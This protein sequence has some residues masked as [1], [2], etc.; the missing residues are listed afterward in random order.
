MRVGIFGDSFSYSLKST[1]FEN[2]INDYNHTLI[3]QIGLR[4]KSQYAIYKEFLAEYKNCELIINF[5]TEHSRFYH[6]QYTVVAGKTDNQNKF[7]KDAVEY[8]YSC[9]YQDDYHRDMQNIFVKNMQDLCKEKN[10]LLINIPCF[11]HQHIEKYYGMWFC[12]NGGL[13]NCSKADYYKTFGKDW[14]GDFMDSRYNHFS[15]DGHKRFYNLFKLHYD[16]YINNKYEYNYIP[17]DSG[18]FN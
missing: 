7:F 16:Y 8:F 15:E 11:E 12:A 18:E 6:P 1:W 9:L 13:I 3:S 10:I 14:G 17:L 4:G 2:F 5:Y